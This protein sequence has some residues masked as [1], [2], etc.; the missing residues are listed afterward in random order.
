MLHDLMRDIAEAG[1]TVLFSAKLLEEAH[2]LFRAEW[3]SSTK[4][5]WRPYFATCRNTPHSRTY[6]ATNGSSGPTF[7]TLS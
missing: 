7:P 4:N 1:R 6:E 2:R 5:S 3:P